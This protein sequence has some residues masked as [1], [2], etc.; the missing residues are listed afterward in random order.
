MTKKIKEKIKEEIK[1][2][3]TERHAEKTGKKVGETGRKGVDAVK[4]F[5]RGLKKGI[6]KDDEE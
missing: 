1:K 6:N 2:S 4:G 5:G 3:K